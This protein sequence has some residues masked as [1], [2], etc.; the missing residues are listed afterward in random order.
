MLIAV[1][2]GTGFI[3]GYICRDLRA[4]GHDLRILVRPTSDTS[5]VKTLDAELVT[6]D[7]AEPRDLPGFVAGADAV[8]HDAVDF[9]V[10]RDD[11][12]ANFRVNLL[13]SLELM[14]FARRAGAGQF[15]FISTGAV[16]ETILDDRPL[17]EAHPLWPGSTYGAYKAA[18]EAFLPAYR[19]Q[20]GFNACAFRP[21]SVYGIHLTRLAASHWFDLVRRVARGQRFASPRGGKIIHVEDVAQAV[22]RA[23]GRDDV[24]G[25]VYELTDC[26]IYDQTVAEFAKAASGSD[27]VIEDLK[28]TGPKHQIVADKARAAFNLGLDRGH[29]GV[30]QY[31][32]ELVRRM[33]E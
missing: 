1:T 12:L 13:R 24:A 32:E 23:V 19:A 3:G 18:V 28:G 29:E 7:L 14:E 17:D 10:C 26:H 31:V 21:T 20:L 30:R 8:V 16:H 2:G 9:R 5:F 22:V 27:A 6:D 33:R 11:Q 25:Q 4:A 15:I